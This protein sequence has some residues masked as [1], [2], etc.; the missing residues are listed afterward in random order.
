MEGVPKYY[1]DPRCKNT[2]DDYAKVQRL[3]DGRLDKTQEEEGKPRVHITDGVGYLIY[4]NFPIKE[5]T[6]WEIEGA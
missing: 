2:I 3:S 4:F 5:P 6:P 1:V